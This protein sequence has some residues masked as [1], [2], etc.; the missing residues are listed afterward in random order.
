MLQIEGVSKEFIH[1]RIYAY[2]STSYLRPANTSNLE[3]FGCKKQHKVRECVVLCVICMIICIYVP[4]GKV[5][6]R[7]HDIYVKSDRCAIYL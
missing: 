4:A 6:E 3:N 2:C 7:N 5:I 1:T